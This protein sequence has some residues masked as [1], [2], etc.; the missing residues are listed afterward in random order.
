[1]AKASEVVLQELPGHTQVV[2]AV[3]LVLKVDTVTLAVAPVVLVH[4]L[5]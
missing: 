4:H 5:Q 1:L 3:V 2:V